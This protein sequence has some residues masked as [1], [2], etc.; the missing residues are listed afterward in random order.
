[1]IR[2]LESEHGTGRVAE[3]VLIIGAAELIGAVS[4]D[5]AKLN[6]SDGKAVDVQAQAS[7]ELVCAGRI[8]F[9]CSSRGG[10][11]PANVGLS[12]SSLHQ[13]LLLAPS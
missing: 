9:V 2:T 13:A 8:E 3:A 4:E 1:M 11:R 7:P 10:P 6:W 5:V 12:F